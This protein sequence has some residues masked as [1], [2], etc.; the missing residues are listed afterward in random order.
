MDAAW[1]PDSLIYALTR[2]LA[3]MLAVVHPLN[4]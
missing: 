4:A 1:V 2:P 3:M